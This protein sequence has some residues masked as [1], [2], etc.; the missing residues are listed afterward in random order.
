MAIAWA[1][2]KSAR[3]GAT[4]ATSR[5]TGR[6]TGCIAKRSSFSTVGRTT[7]FNPTSSQLSVEQQAQLSGRLTTLLRT[8]T[9]DPASGT[10][11][12]DPLRA[13]AFAANLAHYSDSLCERQ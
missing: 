11:T 7:S 10:I 5:L 1:A 9:Y 13:E 8:N 3:S 4:A 6:P 12:I 2:C